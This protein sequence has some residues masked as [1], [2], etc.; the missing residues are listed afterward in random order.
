MLDV[1]LFNSIIS[2][3]KILKGNIMKYEYK[4][5]EVNGLSDLEENTNNFNQLGDEGWEMIEIFEE[6]TS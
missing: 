5:I 2:N 1:L 6:A 3:N 4:I